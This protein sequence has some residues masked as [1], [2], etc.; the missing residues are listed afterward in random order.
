MNKMPPAGREF[1]SPVIHTPRGA[2]IHV[3][4]GNSEEMRQVIPPWRTLPLTCDYLKN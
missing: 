3:P 1:M 4:V 2:R